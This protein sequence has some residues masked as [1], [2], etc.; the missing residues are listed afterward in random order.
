MQKGRGPLTAAAK[1]FRYWFDNSL[2]RRG[3][4]S[5][6]V[7]LAVLAGAL[8]IAIAQ[9]ILNAI[10]ALQTEVSPGG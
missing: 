8:A 5:I 1:N 9:A 6:W 10:P 2:S 3:A 7:A 4:F